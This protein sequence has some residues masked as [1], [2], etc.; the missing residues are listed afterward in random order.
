[1]SF[2]IYIHPWNHHQIRIR[3]IS[4]SLK[5][6][7]APENCGILAPKDSVQTCKRDDQTTTWPLETQ[8]SVL[9]MTPGPHLKC[10]PGKAQSCQEN[11]L[12]V[13]ANIR[14]GPRSPLLRA[15]TDSPG[16]CRRRQWQPTP[17]LL[18]G[19]SQG[20]RSLVGCRLWGRTESDATEAT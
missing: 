13:P 16:K 11:L 1:M 6:A 12:F 5:F 19:E 18:P 3:N 10:L 9:R 7:C 14:G 2:D 20:Q 17:V 4:L 15:F 8:D